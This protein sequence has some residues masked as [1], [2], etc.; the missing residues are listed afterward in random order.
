M[1][2]P[3]FVKLFD[4]KAIEDAKVS[5]TVHAGMDRGGKW[6]LWCEKDC[7]AEEFIKHIESNECLNDLEID[8]FQRVEL[9]PQDEDSIRVVISFD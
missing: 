1:T 5:F 3:E 8:G 9:N 7:T 6:V 2:F 4:K